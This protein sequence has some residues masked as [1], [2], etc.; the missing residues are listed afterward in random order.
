M[1]TPSVPARHRG[2]LLIAIYEF[3]KGVLLILVA[4]SLL[5]MLDR[6]LEAVVRHWAHV[7]RM[8]LH[9]RIV[10]KLAARAG[11]IDPHALKQLSALAFFTGSVHLVQGVGLYLNKR[12]AEYLTVVATSAF[13]PLEVKE[14][15]HHVGP[16]RCLVLAGNVALVVYLIVLLWRRRSA[17]HGTAAV[18]PPPSSPPPAA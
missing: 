16:V 7:L 8:D 1:L 6:D 12:W 11:L 10:E 18:P 4:I 17:G 2:L 9:H 13:I 5:R 14:V 3:T 15:F